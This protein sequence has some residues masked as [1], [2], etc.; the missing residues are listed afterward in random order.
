LA[1]RIQIFRVGKH[2]AMNGVSYDFTES[3]LRDAVAAYD[4]ALHEAPLVVGHPKTDDPAYGWVKSL[5]FADDGRLEIEPC[6]TDAAFME[7]VNE[8][9]FKKISAS[10]YLPDAPSNPKPGSLY[11]RH[12]GF[13]GAQPPAVKGLKSASFADSEEGV[14]EFGDGWTFTNIASLFRRL[15]DYFIDK[16]GIDEADK[17]I[18][19]YAI[20]SLES[21]ARDA[22]VA[23]PSYSERQ[24][25]THVESTDMSLTAE[26]L[27]QKE[28]D[29]LARE[30]A[31]QV[32]TASFSEREQKLTAQE[33]AAQ[34]AQHVSFAEDLIKAGKL[35][36]AHKDQVIALMSALPATT[37]EFG[38]GDGKQTLPPL[39]CLKAVLSAAKP[40]VAF[41]EH[42]AAS[43][44]PVIDAGDAGQLAQAA[45]KYRD[46]QLAAGNVISFSEAMQQVS[47]QRQ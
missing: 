26:Q 16:E 10:W 44:E 43:G 39:D 41:G 27:V 38:E 21:S 12:V 45:T 17:L 46:E 11:I 31:L 28:A 36:P 22:S 9:R 5:H 15:R 23:V 1:K 4:P 34:R 20:Q 7:L 13:L 18:P 33:Q 37:I 6:E 30:Q 25:Q 29:L 8:G 32:Q 24:T 40:Q 14:I 3:M 19:D 35:L 42:A 47:T 2:T